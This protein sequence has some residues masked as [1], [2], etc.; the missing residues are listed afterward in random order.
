MGVYEPDNDEINDIK[1][2]A[3]NFTAKFAEHAN[4]EYIDCNKT[5]QVLYNY[6]QENHKDLNPDDF[7]LYS[8]NLERKFGRKLLTKDNTIQILKDF[9]NSKSS[10]KFHIFAADWLAKKA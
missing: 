7:I 3:K 10:D 2:C 4:L 6:I 9:L 1:L 8:A 5:D